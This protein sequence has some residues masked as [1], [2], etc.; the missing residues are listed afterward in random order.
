MIIDTGKIGK[1]LST[2]DNKAFITG[3]TVGFG[4]GCCFMLL[5]FGLVV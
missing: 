1:V 3:M 4:L 5:M 2:P